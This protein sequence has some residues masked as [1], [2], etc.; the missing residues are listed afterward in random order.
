MSKQ[1]VLKKEFNL[2]EYKNSRSVEPY[3]SLYASGAFSISR[4]F[5]EKYGLSEM[6]SVTILFD[7]EKKVV[8]FKFNKEREKGTFRFR[9]L[10]NV[11]NILNTQNFCARFEI[12]PKKYKGRYSGQEIMD[13]EHGKLFVI[14]LQEKK[15]KKEATSRKV[16]SA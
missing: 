3:I 4:G 14:K 6:N 15:P 1:D 8:A 11:Q 16:D 9:T 7:E 2:I 5:V 13:K 10:K 12:S